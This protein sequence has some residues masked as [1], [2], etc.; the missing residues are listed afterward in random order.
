MNI[1]QTNIPGLIIIKP[2][3]FED[4]R[5]YFFES[6][7]KDKMKEIGIDTEFV[8]DNQSTSSYGVI[9]GLHYQAGAYSQA[10]IIRVLQ[11]EILDVALDIR[12]NSP[13]LGQWECFHLNENNKMQLFIPQGFAHGFSVLSNTAVVLYKCSH[14]Y[15]PGSE[16]G[17]LYNDPDLGIEWKIPSAKQK[18]SE[19]DLHHPLFKD[20][21]YY[22]HDI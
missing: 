16:R 22:D 7:R 4:E 21:E 5:G 15:H 11:G 9:R 8:Q 6:Y 18:L 17:I 10:K 14:F 13:T 20:A 1:S 19:K 2:K 3:L 12:I